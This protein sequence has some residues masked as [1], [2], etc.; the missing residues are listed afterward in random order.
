M[1][2]LSGTP[3]LRC[4]YFLEAA[5]GTKLS[6]AVW[7]SREAGEEGGQRITAAREARGL[8]SDPPDS[9]AFYEVVQEFRAPG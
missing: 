3:G 5:D 6:V 1:E 9:V 4:V 8:E 2:A 7:E